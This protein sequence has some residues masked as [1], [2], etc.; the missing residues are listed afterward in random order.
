[1]CFLGFIGNAG[2][3]PEVSY[4]SSITSFKVDILPATKYLDH[5][6]KKNVIFTLTPVFVDGMIYVKCILTPAV[7][8]CGSC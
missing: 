4:A 5:L 3:N 2:W 7:F 1:M 8:Y 6:Y